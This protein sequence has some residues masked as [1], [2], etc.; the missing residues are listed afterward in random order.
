MKVL[1][2][3]TKAIPLTIVGDLHGS[4]ADLEVPLHSLLQ[5]AKLHMFYSFCRLLP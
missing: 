1:P 2:E 3:P 5:L 4:L